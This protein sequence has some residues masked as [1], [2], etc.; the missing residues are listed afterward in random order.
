MSEGETPLILEAC[1][2]VL[3]LIEVNFSRASKEMDC[4]F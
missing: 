1:P 4:K 2:I 3:G